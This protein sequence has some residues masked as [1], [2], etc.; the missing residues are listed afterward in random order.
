[1]ALYLPIYPKHDNLLAIA[2]LVGFG[3][4]A[5]LT[6]ILILYF[7]ILLLIAPISLLS[8]D[9]YYYWEWSRHLAL[10]YFDGS[11]M[12]AY[13]IKLATVLFGDTLFALN[14]VGIISAAVSELVDIA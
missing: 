4:Q 3:M 5:S 1:M 11:P 14:I 9:S 7:G 12:I 8:F 10:S 13:F 2:S 6:L